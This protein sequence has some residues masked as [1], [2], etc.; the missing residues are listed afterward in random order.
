[1]GEHSGTSESHS[2]RGL[3][4]R[5]VMIAIRDLIEKH[6]PLATAEFDDFLDPRVL[7]VRFDDGLCDADFA[8]IDIQWTTRD[9]YAFHYTDSENVDLRWDRHQ[10]DGDY[11]D[12]T[13]LE[14]YHPPPDASSDPGDV[15]GS[16]I[17]LSR[18][19]LVT[20]AVLKLWRTAYHADSFAPLN[21]GSNPP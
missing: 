18:P 9:D 20:R 4:D 17:G 12:P 21:A 5:A 1:M 7:E 2:L 3:I 11:E 14:Q 13:G 6:E 15:E 10:H 8:R 16:C 19:L